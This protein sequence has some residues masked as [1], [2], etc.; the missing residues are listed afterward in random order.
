[1][2]WFW[3]SSSST[4]GKG[5]D[6]KK[7]LDASL[8]DFLETEQSKDY[9][10]SKSAAPRTTYLDKAIPQATAAQSET[11][12]AVPRESLF[13]DG[14]YAHLWKTYQPQGA[15]ETEAES[16]DPARQML[17]EVKA[18][19]SALKDAALENCA[20]EQETLQMC[21]ELGSLSHRMW[22]RASMC[23]KENTEFSRCYEMQSVSIHGGQCIIQISW[24]EIDISHLEIPAS[25]Q[26]HY[27]I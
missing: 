25:S 21:F 4:D 19:K 6:P 17:D 22:A 10:P 5:D 20:E 24:A 9:K 3:N 27:S 26:L 18:R 16:V 2:S 13:Q 14:R 1:M 12:K 23:H 8:R 7:K 11:E 15:I